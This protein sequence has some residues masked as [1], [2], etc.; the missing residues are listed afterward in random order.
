MNNVVKLSD[1]VFHLWIHMWT[2]LN[3][4]TVNNRPTTI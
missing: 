1:L 3:Y 2:D 4:E